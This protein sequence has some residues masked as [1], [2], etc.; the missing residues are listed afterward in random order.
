MRL[1]VWGRALAPWC[2]EEVE[3]GAAASLDPTGAC[4]VLDNVGFHRSWHEPVAKPGSG[5]TGEMG[6]GR[7]SSEYVQPQPGWSQHPHPGAARAC[8]VGLVMA[9]CPHEIPFCHHRKMETGVEGGG[10]GKRLS[11]E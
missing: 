6:S 5:A 11:L 1:R 4:T 3:Q 2:D 10:G 9:R 7:S 8:G